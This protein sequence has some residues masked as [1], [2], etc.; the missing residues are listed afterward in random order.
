MKEI[1]I[2]DN[3]INKKNDAGNNLDT[4]IESRQIGYREHHEKNGQDAQDEVDQ[5][6]S[7]TLASWRKL[8]QQRDAFRRD[9]PVIAGIGRSAGF[10]LWKDSFSH[11]LPS[12]RQA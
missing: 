1:G 7:R 12:C 6:R 9:D 5:E 3:E 8:G 11:D 4:D 2:T 10:Q